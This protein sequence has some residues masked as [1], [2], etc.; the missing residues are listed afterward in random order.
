MVRRRRG[1][2][3]RQWW[4]DDFIKRASTVEARAL[5]PEVDDRSGVRAR[6]PD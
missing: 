4:A 5:E 1:L 2:E 3:D 6:L